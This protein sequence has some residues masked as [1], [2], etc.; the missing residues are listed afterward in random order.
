MMHSWGIYFVPVPKALPTS[1]GQPT[2]Y[3]IATSGQKENIV[4]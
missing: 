3:I 4:M 1:S 2:S